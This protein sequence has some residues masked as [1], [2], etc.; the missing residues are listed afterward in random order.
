M[1]IV[2]HNILYVSEYEG[3]KKKIYYAVDVERYVETK[4]I[5]PTEWLFLRSW[6][7]AFR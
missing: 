5:V 3:E 1:C 6:F 2:S 7:S 4:V